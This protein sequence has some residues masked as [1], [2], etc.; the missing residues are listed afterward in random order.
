MI[1][2]DYWVV[3]NKKDGRI[4]TKGGGSSTPGLYNS[5]AKALVQVRQQYRPEEWEVVP[6]LLTE[7]VAS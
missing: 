2:K 4:I 5:E 6:V 7:K 3:R 1:C